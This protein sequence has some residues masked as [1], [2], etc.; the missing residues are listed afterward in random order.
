MPEPTQVDID[1][2]MVIS[3]QQDL[4]NQLQHELV[5][6][7]AAVKGLLAEKYAAMEPDDD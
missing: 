1:P 5:I 6:H 2:Q 7:E 3:V 4:I